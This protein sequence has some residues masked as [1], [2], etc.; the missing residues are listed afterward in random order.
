MKRFAALV[1]LTIAT[2]TAAAPV[3]LTCKLAVDGSPETIRMRLNEDNEQVS[4]VNETTG[5]K[6]TMSAE[7][8]PD[9]VQFLGYTVDRGNLSLRRVRVSGAIDNGRCAIDKSKAF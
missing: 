3:A 1:A 6:A 9:A 8:S 2:P 5:S 7:F 4:F